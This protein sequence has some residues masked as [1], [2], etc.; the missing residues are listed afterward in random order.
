MSRRQMKIENKKKA[1]Q[2]RMILIFIM[3]FLIIGILSVDYALREM[4]A[5]E[6]T[7]V[8][9]YELE[10]ENVVLYVIGEKIYIAN[11]KIEEIYVMLETGYSRIMDEIYHLF[12]RIKNV[13]RNRHFF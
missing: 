2:L 13:G 7:R 10:E 3:I 9:G 5:L 4:L 6:D 1:K 12:E 8:L 11:E